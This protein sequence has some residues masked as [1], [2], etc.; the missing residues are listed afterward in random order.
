[1][2]F[3]GATK[4]D[5][6]TFT[7]ALR[8]PTTGQLP[9]RHS[10]SAYSATVDDGFHVLYGVEGLD[11][12][13]PFQLVVLNGPGSDAYLVVQGAIVTTYTP[14]IPGTDVYV[15]EDDTADLVYAVPGVEDA[16]ATLSSGPAPPYSTATAAT[17]SPTTSSDT[18]GS[19]AT[20]ASGSSNAGAV[21]SSASG[22]ASFSTAWCTLA[23]SSALVVAM[24]G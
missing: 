20:V 11:P 13:T 24:R 18:R 6:G 22:A 15:D 8:D 7:F 23:F 17:A 19:T 9:F 4:S 10:V 2:Y 1:M 12:T 5:R 21:V 14:P 3:V 16:I